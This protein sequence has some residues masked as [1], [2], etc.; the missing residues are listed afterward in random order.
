MIQQK[1]FFKPIGFFQF[2]SYLL[3]WKKVHR[4]VFN[5]IM[6]LETNNFVKKNTIL[7]F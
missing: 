4:L 1:N 7:Y 2:V 5:M 3:V 6:I